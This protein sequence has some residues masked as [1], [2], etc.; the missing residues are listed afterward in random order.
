MVGRRRSRRPTR[1]SRRLRERSIR[2]ALRSGTFD[3]CSP[4]VFT[5]QV[6][7]QLDQLS[8]GQP[9]QPVAAYRRAVHVA[10]V[11]R[12]NHG[13]SVFPGSKRRQDSPVPQLRILVFRRLV[14][15]KI[16][17]ASRLC[18]SRENVRGDNL[19]EERSR[20]KAGEVFILATPLKYIEGVRSGKERGMEQCYIAARTAASM[21]QLS[22][23][24]SLVTPQV[25]L[26]HVGLGMDRGQMHARYRT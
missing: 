10:I 1:S 11:Q 16:Q 20:A 21:C 23:Q 22:R 9:F 17:E 4:F 12:A 13:G 19:V 7:S 8:D 26:C 6:V 2:A 25:W 15:F 14:R 3:E 24:L 5:T 18:G